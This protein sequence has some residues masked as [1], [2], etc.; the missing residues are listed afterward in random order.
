MP[1]L[2]EKSLTLDSRKVAKMIDKNH[3]H[4]LRDIENYIN[5]LS[6]NPK[7]DSQ[8]FFIKS[9]YK[10]RG[11]NRTYKCYEV[12]KKGCEFI[13]N[14]LTGEKGAQFTAS[15]INKFHE[16]K[17]ELQPKN[18]LDIL[19]AA[20]D[21]I[22]VAQKQANEA[23][24]IAAETKKETEK[25]KDSFAKIENNWRH[26]V[27]KVFKSIGNQT[28]DFQSYR[29]ES[30]AIL[31]RRARCDLDRRLENKIERMRQNGATKTQIN[32][33]NKLDV[34]EDDPRLTEIYISIVKEFEAKYLNQKVV[35]I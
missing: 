15:Y 29:K 3:S 19:R 12:T 1:N 28:G 17:N 16:M 10:T 11:N 27:N 2:K 18:K 9:S 13:A 4:L 20:I 22:E 14:K 21:Q 32:K 31:N 8:N 30:Y 33:A 5:Y 6:E 34:I 35:N 23:K 24:K 25:I 7:L 26:Y